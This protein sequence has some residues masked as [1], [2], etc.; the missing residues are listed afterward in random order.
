MERAPEASQG[1]R[2]AYTSIG[3]GIISLAM[4]ASMTY[5]SFASWIVAVIGGFVA[6]RSFRLDRSVAAVTGLVLNVLPV[7]LFLYGN[8][9]YYALES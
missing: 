5:L 1:R 3:L 4:L 9:R 6:L 2:L 8:L 7:A